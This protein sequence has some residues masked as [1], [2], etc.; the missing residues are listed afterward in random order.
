MIDE[1]TP[2][3]AVTTRSCEKVRFADEAEALATLGHIRRYGSRKGKKPI[4][5]YECPGCLGWHLTSRPPESFPEKKIASAQGRRSAPTNVP[6]K[7]QT[8]RAKRA[9]AQLEKLR[10][11]R[12]RQIEGYAS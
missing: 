10:T 11:M 9:D 7:L 5:A 8:A 6:A 4:R 2:R 3:E 12:Q 1:Q